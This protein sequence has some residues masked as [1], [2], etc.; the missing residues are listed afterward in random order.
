MRIAGSVLT[1]ALSLEL[2]AQSPVRRPDRISGKLDP[3]RVV[4]LKGNVHPLARP[5]NDRGPVAPDLMLDYVTLHLKPTP[6]QQADL[7]QLLTDLQDPKS[8]HYRQWLTPE[9][10]ADR[11]GAS[12]AG[13]D[14]IAGWLEGQGLTVVTKARGRN[15]IVFKGT[16]ATVQAALHVEIH[17]FLVDGEMQF[18]NVGEP[19]VPA[20]IQPFTI[21]FSGLDDFKPKA[22]PQVVRPIPDA[23]VFGQHAL[24]PVDLWTIYDT[25]PLYEFGLTGN[26]MK[27]AVIGQ[28]DVN[29]SD[30][31]LYQSTVGIPN[32]PPLK[33]L[34]PGDANPGITSDS[35]EAVLD[36]ELAGA[37]V[38][39]AEIL[40][41]FSPT[42]GASI[43]YAVDNAVA[44]VISDSY[45]QCELSVSSTVA[46]AYQQVAQQ[47]NL[48]GV[49]WVAASGDDG[50]ASCDAG[51][52]TA[53]HGISVMLPASVPG[54]TGVG[55]TTLND[56]GGNYWGS[57]NLNATSYIPEVAW[58]DTS[59]AGH[60]SASGGGV[61]N[62]F[63]R[64][65]WQSSIGIPGTTR[66]VPDVAMSASPY[67]DPYVIVLAARW[68][69]LAAPLQRPPFSR[70]SYCLQ[71]RR[72]GGARSEISIQAFIL[73][74][75][76]PQESVQPPHSRL[77]AYFMT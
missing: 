7:D 66:L 21:G 36:L 14:Q 51:V 69:L 67:H 39:S 60:L 17:R 26:G 11:F 46:A 3:T 15:F 19:S 55:G 5:E 8:A 25:L 75:P 32:N 24:A 13:L 10:Y 6:A 71:R 63:A 1:L 49:T 59:T 16:A 62:Y 2:M 33:L 50:A 20:A 22:S 72:S 57:S 27:L 68:R 70:V 73:W 65:T 37:F 29:L 76:S 18:A 52:A 44:P 43:A 40:F 58:N 31:A 48:E 28:S 38:P 61:S 54:V 64:P 9:A 35:T 77:P 45:A 4:A 47:A 12:P 34:V 42:A 56:S 30:I 41:V 74:P 23:I 53:S